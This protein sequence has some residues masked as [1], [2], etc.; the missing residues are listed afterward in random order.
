MN[1]EKWFA[2]P[3]WFDFLDQNWN[4]IK[5]HCLQLEA[6]DKKNISLSN[7]GGWHSPPLAYETDIVLKP[8]FDAIKIKLSEICQQIDPRFEVEISS[9]WIIINRN[10]AYN[11]KHY[12]PQ[13]A[14]SGV[15]Y[16]S[17]DSGS[18]DIA[19]IRGDLKEHYPIHTFDS[20]LFDNEVTYRPEV[21]KLLVFPSWLYHYVNRNQSPET[22]ISIAFNT[23]Q[24]NAPDQANY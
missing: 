5:D 20:N 13:S 18:G 22:R 19:F 1:L 16:I 21:G 3:I 7:I 12:H 15:I 9:A 8:L 6:Q 2:N 11:A 24:I 10:E 23:R 14:L 4:K 17:A